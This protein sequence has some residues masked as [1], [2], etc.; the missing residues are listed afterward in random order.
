MELIDAIAVCLTI[1]QPRAFEPLP[2]ED[3]KFMH[4]L[5]VREV[6]QMVILKHASQVIEAQPKVWPVEVS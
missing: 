1:P 4:N 2:L 6:A 3:K 5:A